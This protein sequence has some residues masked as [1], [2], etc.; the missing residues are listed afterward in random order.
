M[1]Q[2]SVR[3][4]HAHLLVKGVSVNDPIGVPVT[5]PIDDQVNVLFDVTPLV[6]PVSAAPVSACY[7]SLVLVK[8][9]LALL[10]LGTIFHDALV[11]E[12]KET[13]ILLECYLVLLD[14]EHLKLPEH[15]LYGV[16]IF[17]VSLEHVEELVGRGEHVVKV[18]LVR[19]STTGDHRHTVVGK[20]HHMVRGGSKKFLLILVIGVQVGDVVF[21]PIG[22]VFHKEGWHKGGARQVCAVLYRERFAVD[23]LVQYGTQRQCDKRL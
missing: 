17:H 18:V 20:V 8:L 12:R 13:L 21:V 22:G 11:D 6:P 3:V 10:L 1:E 15:V 9:D 2:V 19:F 5:G 4:N 23:P 14:L 7:L 16:W